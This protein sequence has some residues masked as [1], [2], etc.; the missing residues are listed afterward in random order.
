MEG[1]HCLVCDR[2]INGA[3]IWN[4]SRSGL[5]SRNETMFSNM[6][7]ELSSFSIGPQH[8][9]WSWSLSSDGLFAVNSTR[10]HVDSI[11]LP[12]MSPV[13]NWY[14]PIPRKVNVLLWRLGV[15][16]LPTRLNLLMRGLEINSITCPVCSQNLETRDHI[17]FVCEVASQIWVKIRRWVDCNM[18]V[19]NSWSDWI[20]WFEHWSGS[21]ECKNK[22][23]AIAAACFWFV[24]KHRNGIVFNNLMVKKSEIFDSICNFSYFW[25]R[26]RGKCNISWASWLMNP[27]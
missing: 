12:S 15:E 8:D 20:L 2:Y 16:R 24:W 26:Y 14:K 9:T 21:E 5:G 7:A 11:M 17:F 25:T 6:L 27:L 23:I 18:P 13:T 10:K 22:V 1:H 19:F 4:W 3:W